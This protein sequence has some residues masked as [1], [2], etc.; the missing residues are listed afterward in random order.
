MTEVDQ[1]DISYSRSNQ[2]ERI[3]YVDIEIQQ[4]GR[5]KLCDKELELVEI[6]IR[7]IYINK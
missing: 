3:N 5:I 6:N 2:R 1:L 4:K 7:E